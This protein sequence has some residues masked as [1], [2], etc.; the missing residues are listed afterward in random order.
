M[1][2]CACV[3]L[4]VFQCLSVCVHVP[5]CVSVS[6]CVCVCLRVYQCVPTCVPVSVCVCVCMHASA[7]IVLGI[8]LHAEQSLTVCTNKGTGV[9]CSEH[10]RTHTDACT[11]THAHTHNAPC[12][13]FALQPCV[14]P[15]AGAGDACARS[16]RPPS[17]LPLRAAALQ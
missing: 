15:L 10:T 17:L 16:P 13:A 8:K 12:R 11:H 4:R 1:C 3:Y 7:Y 2:V 9:V 5:T 14:H 6:V